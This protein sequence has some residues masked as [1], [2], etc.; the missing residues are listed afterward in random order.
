[1]ST[2][3]ESD[4]AEGPTAPTH[5]QPQTWRYL[6]HRTA[7]DF[8][9]HRG[10]DAAASLTFFSVLAIFPAGLAIMA[11]V[12]IVS[13]SAEVRERLLS[14]FDGVAPRAVADTAETIL[15]SVSGSTGADIT[16]VTSIAVALWSSSIYVSAFGRNVN[17]IYG[18]AEGRPYWKRKPLQLGLTVVLLVAVM[19]M[20]AVVMASTPVLRN[21]G[22]WLGIGDTALAIWNVARWAVFAAAGAVVIAILYKGTGN[23]RLPGFRWLGLGAA[24]ALVVMAAA[25]MGFGFYVGNFARYNVTF[26]AFAGAT[27]FLIWLFLI[28]TAL[29]IGA[30][31]NA[32]VERG[33]ELEA[34][35]PAEERLQLPLRDDTAIRARERAESITVHRGALIRQGRPLPPRPDSWVRRG[36]KWIGR[37]RDRLRPGSPH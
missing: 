6:L 19:V 24:L 37:V 9:G 34:G 10:F 27:V 3:P 30:E 16:L 13:D 31:F 8:V 2:T 12:G 21:L 32:Q 15:T 35:M 5:L 33:R 7:G 11:V 22:S 18:V 26:G 29:L 1:M 28:N 23:V 36:K 4:G 17:R 20:V 14:L 25:S